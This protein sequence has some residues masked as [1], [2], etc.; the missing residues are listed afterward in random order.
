MD[1]WSGWTIPDVH[2]IASVGSC[3]LQADENGKADCIS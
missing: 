3:A 1:G 2:A